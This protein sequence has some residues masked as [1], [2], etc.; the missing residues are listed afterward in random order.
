MQNHFCHCASAQSTINSLTSSWCDEMPIVD[1]SLRYKLYWHKPAKDGLLPF[2][3]PVLDI[4]KDVA[5][6]ISKRDIGKHIGM[7]VEDYLKATI[8]SNAKEDAGSNGIALQNIG[9]LLE[10]ELSLNVEQILLGLSQEMV[11]ILLW[12][13]VTES[14][15][16]FRWSAD[17]KVA[18]E[19]PEQT[20][21]R[22]EV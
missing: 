7:D 17:A 6:F 9:I 4:G 13:Y 14:S 12:P 3:Y 11:I 20:I 21:H 18:L 5:E 16:R 15:R 19:F 10:P 8:R 2:S 22:L 1:N